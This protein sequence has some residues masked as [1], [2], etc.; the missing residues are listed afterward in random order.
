LFNSPT[1]INNVETFTAVP[2]ILI[3]SG[4]KWSQKAIG[5]KDE[6]GVKLYNVIG[7]CVSKSKVMEYPVGVQVSIFII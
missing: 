1:V 4:K 6:Y 2:I 3:E 7:D 5:L